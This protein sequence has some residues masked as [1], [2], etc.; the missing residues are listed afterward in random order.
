M[1]AFYGP[2]CSTLKCITVRD[3]ALNYYFLINNSLFSFY[4]E[5]FLFVIDK[6]LDLTK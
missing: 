1:E 4:A 5:L 6:L 2:C 3:I